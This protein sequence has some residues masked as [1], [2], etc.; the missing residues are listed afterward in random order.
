MVKSSIF[1]FLL[2]A[3]CD[4]SGALRGSLSDEAEDHMVATVGVEV[5]CISK[6][7]IE[8]WIGSGFVVSRNEIITANHVVDCGTGDVWSLGVKD[9]DGNRYE[10]W[11][12][13]VDTAHDTALVRLTGTQQPFTRRSTLGDDPDVGDMVCAATYFPERL[14]HCGLVQPNTFGRI[15]VTQRVIPGNSGSAWYDGNSRV[16]GIVTQ[17]GTCGV[18]TECYGYGWPVSTWRGLMD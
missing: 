2:L 7:G 16:V 18:G 5:E 3:S 9:V 15:M 10:G 14:Y 12:A 11:V 13:G 17:Y 6:E 4:C 8:G 1:V